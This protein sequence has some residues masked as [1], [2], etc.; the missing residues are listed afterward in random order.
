VPGHPFLEQA[1]ELGIVE[2]KSVG[3]VEAH[4]AFERGVIEEHSLE[5]RLLLVVHRE[6]HIS[7][8]EHPVVH[9]HHRVLV[10][11]CRS[12]VKVLALAEHPFRR[13]AAI[14]V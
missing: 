1:H 5:V 12:H 9:A 7:P 2:G 3:N 13:R 4:D 6:D 8:V 11:A 14:A 10:R